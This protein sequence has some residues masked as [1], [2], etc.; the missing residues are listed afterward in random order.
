LEGS[1]II[2]PFHGYAVG[3]GQEAAGSFTVRE[4]PAL[5]VGG[6]VFVRLSE[7]YANGFVAVLSD[8]AHDCT[9]VP[10]FELAV[11]APAEMV[12][13]NAF[14]SRHFASV[15]GISPGPFRVVDGPPG[16]LFVESVLRVPAV[17]RFQ[18]EPGESFSRVPFRATIVS[19][20]LALVSLGG[21]SPY[22][23]ITGATP[24]EG[25]GCLVRVSLALPERAWG[26]SPERKDYGFLLEYSRQGL[27]EDRQVWENVSRTARQHLTREDEPVLRFHRFCGQFRAP[28]AGRRD[29]SRRPRGAP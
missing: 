7:H 26:S 13:E 21:S 20:G 12:I 18:P 22:T 23:V 28:G 8:L 14:D 15:H 10:G 24:R 5:S 17:G 9:L 27:E 16:V 25:D 1:R 2:C 19:P 3:L 6:I 11:D 4:H 29:R